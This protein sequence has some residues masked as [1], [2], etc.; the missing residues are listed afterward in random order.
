MDNHLHP[1]W[2]ADA[3]HGELLPSTGVQL[4]LDAL[5]QQSGILTPMDI[6]VLMDHLELLMK[7]CSQANI[8]AGKNWVV[9]HCQT[10]QLYDLLSRAMVAIAISRT[11]FHDKL[12]IIY[13]INDI[14]SHSERK[15]QRWIK[16]ALY[17]HL[18]PILRVAY[19]YPGIDD[20]QRQR[21]IKDDADYYEPMPAYVS[22]PLQ[23]DE[24]N[25][26][27]AIQDNLKEFLAEDASTQSN[28]ETTKD[29][30]W[31][32]GYLDEFYKAVV[33]KRKLAFS[34]DPPP[35][36]RR[37]PGL[38]LYLPEGVLVRLH[39]RGLAPGLGLDLVCAR[40]GRLLDTVGQVGAGVEAGV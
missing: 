21:V 11:T 32:K 29:E 16:D 8:Q 40:V 10:P 36:R 35:R 1:A 24:S 22:I 30:G 31:H 17:P 5:V 7:D 33:E 9:H 4:A 28:P 14:L 38:L 18:V 37:R 25:K 34:K 6:G 23:K 13:L 15:Q 12:H 26:R 19:Y 2:Q 3:T 27:D 39:I 20:S